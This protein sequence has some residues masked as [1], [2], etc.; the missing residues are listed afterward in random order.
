MHIQHSTYKAGGA[1][2]SQTGAEQLAEADRSRVKLA[3]AQVQD[4]K[5]GGRVKRDREWTWMTV[6]EADGDARVGWS[7]WLGDD[8]NQGEEKQMRL[9][10]RQ[11]CGVPWKVWMH[12]H[13]HPPY[14]K[15]YLF[16]FF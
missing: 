9:Q 7:R 2:E 12:L 1:A 3:Q 11:S 6:R 4:S 16:F 5:A 14:F 10:Y 15:N 13:N 8:I